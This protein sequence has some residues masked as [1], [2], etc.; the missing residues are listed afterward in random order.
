VGRAFAPKMVARKKVS[1]MAETDSELVDRLVKRHSVSPSAVK[2]VM[3]ALR[4]G[5][6]RMAQFSHADFGGMSQW[7]PGMSMVGDMFNAQL[8][9]KLDALCTDIAAHLEA[10]E[11]ADDSIRTSSDEVSYRSMRDPKEW[12]PSG[13]G[14]P[15]AVGVQNDLR[16]A[17]FPEARRLIIDD[18][19]S[20]SIYDTGS[21]RIFGV[22]QAQSSGQTLSFTSQDG[23][24]RVADLQKVDD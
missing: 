15:G 5:G 3:T 23:L 19:G 4:S 14:R 13:L 21:H 11:T 10:S 6:G 12:W 24:V 8:K 20:V 16:Y 9:S 2:V 1:F 18:R 22:A 17:V 7:S